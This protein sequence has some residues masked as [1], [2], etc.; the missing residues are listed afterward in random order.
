MSVRD[1]EGVEATAKGAAQRPLTSP[2][3]LEAAIALVD[4]QFGGLPYMTTRQALFLGALIERE[5]LSSLLELGT[6]HGKSTAYMAAVL[7]AIGRGNF[8]N[9]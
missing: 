5:G 6:F 9:N 3:D 1:Q 7:E 2:S 4:K 8:G